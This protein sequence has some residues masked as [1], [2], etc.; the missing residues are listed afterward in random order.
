MFTENL[1]KSHCSCY[2]EFENE[3]YL[4][5]LLIFTVKVA[6]NV[7]L[8]NQTLFCHIYISILRSVVLEYP[9]AEMTLG[10]FN[11][12]F[13]HKFMFLKCLGSVIFKLW[14]DRLD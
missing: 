13:L 6:C 9:N 10:M 2:L 14:Q 5:I 4:N 8:F 7:E 1:C 12:Q 3:I 11:Y